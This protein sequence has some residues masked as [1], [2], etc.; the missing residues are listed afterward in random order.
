MELNSAFST[1]LDLV[2]SNLG[3]TLTFI[4][5]ITGSIYY[6]L[7][8]LESKKE[9][10]KYLNSRLGDR[11]WFHGPFKFEC[12]DIRVIE[13]TN[14]LYRIKKYIFGEFD[15]EVVVAVIS[16]FSFDDELKDT[17]LLKPAEEA[18]H[19]IEITGSERLNT[20]KVQVTFVIDTVDKD[21]LA[22]T[23]DAILKVLDYA[24]ENLDG[25]TVGPG[26]PHSDAS[27]NNI[28]YKK[29]FNEEKTEKD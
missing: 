5:V 23:L 4:G 7:S 15:G 17:E 28:P 3:I 22:R 20:E 19:D 1:F 8:N 13:Q 10:E 2:I 26:V 14:T 21:E 25:F 29:L 9:R 6:R 18:T 24:V 27:Y 11:Q 12:D 16:N